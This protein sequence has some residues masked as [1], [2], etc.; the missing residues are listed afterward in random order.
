M[1]SASL[2]P[3]EGPQREAFRGFLNNDDGLASTTSECQWHHQLQYK[4]LAVVVAEEMVPL[5][6]KGVNPSLKVGSAFEALV[7]ASQADPSSK[8][9]KGPIF[10]DVPLAK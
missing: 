10:F 9:P 7:V 2:P 3:C 5:N 1:I 8:L 4:A 6:V